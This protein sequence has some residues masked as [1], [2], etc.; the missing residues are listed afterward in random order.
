[1]PALMSVL[2]EAHAWMLE[3]DA[4]SHLLLAP[5]RHWE[6]VTVVVWTCLQSCAQQGA[7][8]WVEQPVSVFQET[9]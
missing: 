8:S 1:M 4:D 2:E 3:A 7:S 9:Y 5:P 6:W